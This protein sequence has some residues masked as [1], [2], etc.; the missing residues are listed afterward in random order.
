MIKYYSQSGEDFIA[1]HYFDFKKNGFFVEIGAFD[2][3]HLSNTYS[4]ERAGWRGICVEP[5]PE[6]FPICKKNRPNSICLHLACIEDENIHQVEFNAEKLGLLSG[7]N[8]DNHDVEKRYNNRGLEYTP[9]EKIIV[10]ST[11]LNKILKETS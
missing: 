7:I 6:Y 2:G 1:W 3:I 8:I 9:A 11:T 5:H 10:K 4:F